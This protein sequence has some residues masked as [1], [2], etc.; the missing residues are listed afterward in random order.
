MK[1]KECLKDLEDLKE[2][3]TVSLPASNFEDHRDFPN[4]SLSGWVQWL[5][6]SHNHELQLLRQASSWDQGDKAIVSAQ[7]TVE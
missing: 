1:K 5:T 7:W 4:A 3:A 2:Q 6:G